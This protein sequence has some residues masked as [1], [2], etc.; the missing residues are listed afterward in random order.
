MTSPLLGSLA[1]RA[2]ELVRVGAVLGPAFTLR[3]AAWMLGVKVAALL[4]PL[5]EAIAASVLVDE[6]VSLRFADE[7]LREEVLDAIPESACLALV[8]DAGEVRLRGARTDGDGAG[9]T[10]E[11]LP[12][13]AGTVDSSAVA[14][15]PRPRGAVDAVRG[16]V[17]AGQVKE[18]VEV[19]NTL[20]RAP[21]DPLSIAEIRCLLAEI[22]VVNGHLT[23]GLAQID[24]VLD[25]RSLPAS[26]AVSATATCLLALDLHEPAQAREPAQSLLPTGSEVRARADLL[27]AATALSNAKWAAGDLA[28]SLQ[29]GRKAEHATQGLPS[30]DALPSPSAAGAPLWPRLALATKLGAMGEVHEAEGLVGLAQEA[31]HRLGATTY[32]PA[33]LNIKARLLLRDG[34]LGEAGEA[35]ATSIAL[36]ERFGAHSV[37]ASSLA[38]R[39]RLHVLGDDGR[40]AG[41]H[42]ALYR[43][44]LRRYPAAVESHLFDWVELLV[45]AHRDGLQ[46]AG[47][48]LSGSFTD[49]VT[50]QHLLAEEPGAAAWFVR[51]ARAIHEE[52]LARLA[53]HTAE[54]VARRNPGFASLDASALEARSL[55]E[56]HP[57]GLAEALA[58]HRD[59]W[60]RELAGESLRSLLGEHDPLDSQQAP[61][62]RARA[63]EGGGNGAAPTSGQVIRT[64]SALRSSE[65]TPAE[66]RV[67]QMVALG[68][69]NQQVARRLSVSPHTVNFHLRGIFR[70][71]RVSSRAQV[72][73]LVSLDQA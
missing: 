65:L 49:L 4:R 48:L 57:A 15:I 34:R 10:Y 28:G 22:L 31:A 36:S 46:T 63:Q 73:R 3:E 30:F 51:A 43:R 40:A 23:E 24:L 26:F 21:M 25:D 55:L 8:Q 19:G 20:L 61:A 39:A 41:E 6:G 53:V 7:S 1:A 66:Q 58:R 9:S 18:A 14:W 13:V 42:V 71:L 29:L 54:Q 32:L 35:A 33:L 69:T 12:R 47:R 44:E 37:L 16:L 50:S 56:R 27:L 70:K 2:V 5:D 60:A 11:A 38:T 67:A 59:P 45:V 72:A 62:S 68:L 64:P 17:A 52:P